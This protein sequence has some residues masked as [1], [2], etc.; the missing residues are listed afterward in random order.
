MQSIRLCKCVFRGRRLRSI[1]CLQV[2]TVRSG[3]VSYAGWQVS[4]LST[5]PHSNTTQILKK[6]GANVGQQGW[7]Y[8]NCPLWKP[9]KYYDQQPGCSWFQWALEYPKWYKYPKPIPMD[10]KAKVLKQ[11]QKL[12]ATKEKA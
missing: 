3:R 5:I 4:R 11:Q 12:D 9:N 8:W 6:V 7:P 2:G 10:L 1:L